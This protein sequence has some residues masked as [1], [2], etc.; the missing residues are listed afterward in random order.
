MPF[1]PPPP[2]EFKFKG[3]GGAPPAG[4]FDKGALDLDVPA[5]PS[6]PNRVASFAATNEQIVPASISLPSAPKPP[7]P[8]VA[9]TPPPKPIAK[10]TPRPAPP[11]ATPAIEDDPL[12]RGSRTTGVFS[13][14]EGE[15]E[16][17]EE[18]R[19]APGM[20]FGEDADAPY[21][22]EVFGE[23][24]ALKKQCGESTD[25]LTF[26]KFSRKLAA[27]RDT[28]IEKHG[29]KTVRFQVYV[30]DGKAALKASPVRG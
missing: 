7:L 26:A 10:P 29:C 21:F 11:P 12:E 28:L 17:D 5:P 13:V 23:F 2:S 20:G 15:G 18:T 16:H 27:N 30:K 1:A 14:E 4:A 22:R 25:S 3:S 8:S 9:K 6:T 24:V 19:V